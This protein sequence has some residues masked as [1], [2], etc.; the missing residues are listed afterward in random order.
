MRVMI[1]V[2]ALMCSGLVHGGKW[3]KGVTILGVSTEWDGS[4]RLWQVEFEGNVLPI[5][6]AYTDENSKVSYWS[7]SDPSSMAHTLYTT[8]LSAQAQ[9]LAVD[10]KFDSCNAR[11]GLAWRGIRIRP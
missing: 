10:L 4:Y 1:F 11:Y 3:L 6:C 2:A 7:T 9:G 5:G 8:A